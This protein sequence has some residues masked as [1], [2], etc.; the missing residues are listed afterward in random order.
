MCVTAKRYIDDLAEADRARIRGMV[1]LEALGLSTTAIWADGADRN[2]RQDLL[3]VAKALGMP[4][5]E[6]VVAA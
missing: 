4:M 3:G 6:T 5:R 2:L 1:N